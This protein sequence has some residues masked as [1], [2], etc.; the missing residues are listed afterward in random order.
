MI[1]SNTKPTPKEFALAQIAPYVANHALCGFDGKSCVYLTDSG[2]M[3]V[4]GA[5]M[6]NPTKFLGSGGIGTIL[7]RYSQEEV[8]KPESV[9]ILSKVEWTSL[10][11]MHDQIAK[12]MPY[13]LK[14]SVETLNLFTMDELKE[15]AEKYLASV[16]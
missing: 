15:A 6:I 16:K 3:C 1:E 14:N 4:A 12:N 10:Q 5:N 9:N 13:S 8:F 11:N 7:G 2:K